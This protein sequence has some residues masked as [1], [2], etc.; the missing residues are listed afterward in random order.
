MSKTSNALKWVDNKVQ[1]FFGILIIWYIIY[2]I[3]LWAR[4]IIW[5]RWNWRKCYDKT[6]MDRNR[7][8]DYK[9][10]DSKWN[11]KRTSAEWAKT[12]MWK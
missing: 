11:I 5:E 6:S 12:L 8:N 9:C 4:S 7:D 3:I 10:E 1:I 2:I